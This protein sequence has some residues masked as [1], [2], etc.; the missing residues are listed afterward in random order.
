MFIALYLGWFCFVPQARDRGSL[1]PRCLLMVMSLIPPAPGRIRLPIE[2]LTRNLEKVMLGISWRLGQLCLHMGFSCCNFRKR[3]KAWSENT[4]HLWSCTWD[5]DKCRCMGRDWQSL[6][7]TWQ[8]DMTAQLEKKWNIWTSTGTYVNAWQRQPAHLTLLWVAFNILLRVDK[9]LY[10]CVLSKTKSTRTRQGP[11]S[12]NG[13]QVLRRLQYN[14]MLLLQPGAQAPTIQYIAYISTSRRLDAYN[15]IQCLNYDQVLRRL[16]YCF[17]D[18]PALPFP[19]P[20]CC[21]WRCWWWWWWRLF[22]G[23]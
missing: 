15:T 12:P 8:T 7:R 13:S 3:K 4:E 10:Q 22:S 6:K 14:T 18:W 5:R 21:P 16:I 19:V 23:A 20:W 11:L 9:A 2:N 1:G 17:A